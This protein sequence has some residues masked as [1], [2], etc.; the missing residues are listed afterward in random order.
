M[1]LP[2]VQFDSF[3]GIN[4]VSKIPNLDAD[5]DLTNYELFFQNNKIIV[6]GRAIDN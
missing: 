6:Y 1:F 5:T 3:F 2:N 4:G